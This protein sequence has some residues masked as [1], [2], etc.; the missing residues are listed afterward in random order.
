MKTKSKGSDLG[1]GEI[2]TPV[3]ELMTLLILKIMNWSASGLVWGANRYLFSGRRKSKLKKIKNESLECIKRDHDDNNLGYSVSEGIPISLSEIDRKYHNVIVGASGFGKTVLLDVLMY[4][5]LQKG[6]PVIFIDPK[7]DNKS[8]NQ[9]IGLCKLAGRDFSIFSEHYK[10]KGAVSI[11]PVKEG[12]ST[13]I[14]DRIHMSFNWSEEHY[15]VLCYRALKT[16][17]SKIQEKKQEVSLNGILS[18][19]KSKRS[20]NHMLY[21]I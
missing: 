17:I 15:E 18:M 21:L 4:H 7:G 11:N 5:D 3:M 14:A 13:H 2:L 9:F 12:R 8:L 10:G 6:R 1:I 20:I 16:S 19:L